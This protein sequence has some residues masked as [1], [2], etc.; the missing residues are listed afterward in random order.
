MKLTE[1]FSL[2]EFTRS[3]TA[4]KYGINNTPNEEQIANLK[5]LCENVLEPLRQH[6]NVPIIIGS[7]FRC[8][9][10]NSHPEVRGATNSQHM[11]GEAADIQIPDTATGNQWFE[12]MEDNLQFDQLIKE[13]ST[14]TSKSF[15]I[16]VSF[17]RACGEP[18]RTSKN[19]QQVKFLIKNK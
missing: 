9:K 3:S 1:H 15:W 6:F 4:N 17:R 2:E 18:G 13:K 14:K 8:P 5:A 7:G 16:H 11:T 10:L 19:R 12:W